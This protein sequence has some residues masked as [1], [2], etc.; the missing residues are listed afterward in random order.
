[1]P[2]ITFFKPAGV[3]TRDLEEVPLTYEEVESLRL[4]DIEGMDQEPAAAEMNVSRPTFQRILASA[5]AKVAD[6][7]LNGKAIRIT[8]GNYE[9]TATQFRCRHGHR[10]DIPVKTADDGDPSL[11]PTCRTPGT[12]INGP[13]GRRHGMRHQRNDQRQGRY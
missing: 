13:G 7:I 12:R 2:G 6:A 3:Q 8:G 10:W 4:K 9:M 11:C 5:R 1:M